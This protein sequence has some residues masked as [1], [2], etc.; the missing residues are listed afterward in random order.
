M[1]LRLGILFFTLHLTNIV[2][3]QTDSVVLKPVVIYGMPEEKYLAGSSIEKLDSALGDI[4]KSN[5]LGE[6]LSFQ[7]PVYFRNYGSG[8]L[9]GISMRGTSPQHT[10]VLWNGININSFS[11]GQSDFSILPAVAFDEVK[12]YSGGGSAQFGSGVF[13]GAVLLQTGSDEAPLF[14]VRQEAGS[15]G[16]YFT[17]IK[18]SF[19][20]NAFAFSSSLYRICSKNNFII[21]KTGGRQEHASFFQQGFVQNIRYNFSPT[22]MLQLD[23]WVHDADREIQPT[24]GNLNG[25]D[26]Q[27]D[28]NHRLSIS[29][30]ENS[31]FGLLKTGGGV[32]NDEIVFSGNP[33][34]VLRWIAFVNHQYRFS[35]QWNIQTSIDWNHIIGK[36][37]EYGHE[38]KEDRVDI[39]GSLQRRFEKVDLSAS[40]RQPLITNMKPPLLPYIGA[41]IILFETHVQTLQVSANASRNF[42]AP[43]L[44]DRYWG[45]VG[46]KDLLPE[47]SY[48]IES[49]VSWTYRKAKLSATAFYQLVDQWILWSPDS[50]NTY[51]PDNIKKV[52]ASG[53]ESAIELQWKSGSFSQ[54]I[55]GSYQFTKSITEEASPAEAASI[56]KQLI[57]TPLHTAAASIVSRLKEWSVN[58]FLQYAGVRFTEASNSPIYTL[59]PYVLTDFSVGKSFIKALHVLST[60]IV[61]KNIFDIE[62][63][64]YSSRAMP[65]RNFNLQISYQLKHKPK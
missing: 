2:Q 64:Q 47:K 15:F 43:T 41:D 18:T 46:R 51:R 4:Y 63:K 59:D 61:V 52:K 5:H 42:R 24:T 7:F 31:R 37:R 26:E 3:A 40:L 57:Y 6:I 30:R 9:S 32:V 49:G 58:I 11:L 13:G 45:S 34:N 12:V 10:A 56:G 19:Y 35:N 20:K 27:Q 38:P 50:T 54:N 36:I 17:A 39:A 22:Q 14:S 23:Y 62:Y 60:Q 21:H 25:R 65:G 8:M 16:K 53:Y 33:S 1:S 44:N 48:A 28:R 55:R 29:Y